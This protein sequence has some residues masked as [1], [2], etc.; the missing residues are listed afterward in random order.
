MEKDHV[1]DVKQDGLITLR[2]LNGIA[3]V[4]TQAK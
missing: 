1:K 2:I 4:F 3:W